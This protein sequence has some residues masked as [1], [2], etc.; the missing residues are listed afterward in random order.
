MKIGNKTFRIVKKTFADG[1]SEY[2]AEELFLNLWLFK[3]WIEYVYD[4]RDYGYGTLLCK[5]RF[6]TYHECVDYLTKD[7]NEKME[8]W[9]K[10]RLISKNIYY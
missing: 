3:I 4:D 1:H 8:H 6:P 10:S 2:H 9:K 5:Y 7:V